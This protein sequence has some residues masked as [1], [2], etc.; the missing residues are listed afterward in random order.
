MKRALV[1]VLAMLLACGGDTPT[2]RQATGTVAVA[3]TGAALHDVTHIEFKVVDPAGSCGDAAIASKI[4]EIEEEPLPAH[5]LPT[6]DGQSHPFA[7]GLFVLPPG[8]YLACAT[9]LK[10]DAPP[11]ASDVCPAESRLV[12]V[13]AGVTN[14]IVLISQCGGD[15]NGGLDIVVGFNT[16]P[17]ID[18]L[19]I[20][21]SKFIRACEQAAIT[22]V[23]SDV[24]DDAL[25]YNWQILSPALGA[26]LSGVD[27]QRTFDPQVPADYVISV[28]VV[29]SNNTMTSITFPI[30]VSGAPC[31]PPGAAWMLGSGTVADERMMDITTDPSGNIIAGGFIYGLFCSVSVLN[32]IASRTAIVE[33]YS[34]GGLLQWFK[35][36]GSISQNDQV[37]GIE[38]AADGDVF[39]T[40]IFGESADFGCGEH[41]ADGPTDVFLVKLDGADGSC[42]WDEVFGGSG[43]DLVSG[44]AVSYVPPLNTERVTIAG[45]F[46]S[47]SFGVPGFTPLANFGGFDMFYLMRDGTTGERVW[48]ERAGDAQNDFINAIAAN[49]TAIAIAG[50]YSSN[51]FTLGHGADAEVSPLNSGDADTFVAKLD[52]DSVPAWI[53]ASHSTG[54]DQAI[55]IDIDDVDSIVV[56][57]QFF[58]SFTIGATTHTKIGVSDAF[59]FELSGAGAAQWSAQANADDQAY[60]RRAVFDPFGDVRIFGDFSNAVAFGGALLTAGAAEDLFLAT[61]SGGDGSALWAISG[62]SSGDDEARGL[63]VD[64]LN[65]TF[66]AGGFGDSG[67][68]GFSLGGSTPLNSNGSFDR[69]FG[70][71]TP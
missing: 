63:H 27:E 59:V 41:F 50:S 33:K 51:G 26:T 66:V 10:N 21:P 64:A 17:H 44:V 48:E 34:A 67:G 31:G 32:C 69:F 37:I 54:F 45:S 61:L 9:P 12:T 11:T 57:G 2:P 40:G 62:G 6:G 20:S 49:D 19:I 58:G 13:T 14:E 18:D 70:R 24:D 39:V 60:V 65:N 52:I 3:F 29:D 46:N 16:N 4:I 71:L 43:T 7:D 8:D 38:T 55:G 47:P 36:F 5:L 1:L 53:V 30:H 68:T 56:G 42:I 28:E 35:P 15:D 23:A 22:V 25:S